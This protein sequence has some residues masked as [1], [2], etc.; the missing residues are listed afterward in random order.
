MY[1]PLLLPPPLPLFLPPHSYLH[2]DQV[3]ETLSADTLV[4]MLVS[5]QLGHTP[6]EPPLWFPCDTFDFFRLSFCRSAFRPPK[7]MKCAGQLLLCSYCT[8]SQGG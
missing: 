3:S 7:S 4:M 2:C 1:P 6:I 5:L 8:G